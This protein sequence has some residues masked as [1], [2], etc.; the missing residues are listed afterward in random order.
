MKKVVVIAVLLAFILS[1]F[2]FVQSFQNKTSIVEDVTVSDSITFGLAYGIES[3]AVEIV[4]GDEVNVMF[5]EDETF[6]LFVGRK[7]CP[8]C[9][10]TAPEIDAAIKASNVATFHYLDTEDENNFAFLEQQQIQ[11]VPITAF[12]IDG[13]VVDVIPGYAEEVIF[14]SI[15]ETF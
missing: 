7:T 14:S 5:F 15:L 12:V 9:L 6:V 2:Y 10:E 1:V 8:Y 11:G 3:P 13:E 4:S